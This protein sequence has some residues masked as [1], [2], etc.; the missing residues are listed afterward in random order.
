MR[1]KDGMDL[2]IDEMDRVQ[3]DILC[4]QEGYRRRVS[5]EEYETKGGHRA[6]VAKVQ[7]KQHRSI[8]FLVNKQWTS[9]LKAFQACGRVAAI[10]LDLNK[11]RIRIINACC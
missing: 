11:V 4:F 3:W 7:H 2:L 9:K 10:D 5:D 1:K 6:L 8:G